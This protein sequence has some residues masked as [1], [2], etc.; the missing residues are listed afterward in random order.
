M[1]KTPAKAAQTGAPAAIAAHWPATEIEM[2]DAAELIPYARNAR[3]HPEEQIAQI[4]ASMQRFGFTIPMLV[5]EDGTII[6]GHG[7]LMA[8]QRLGLEQVPVMVARGWSDEDRRLYTLADNRLA[9]TSEWD[10]DMLRIELDELRIEAGQDALDMMAFSDIDL[11]SILP[12]AL[13]EAGG[14]D[15]DDAPPVPEVPTTQPGDVWL[16]GEHRLMCGDSTSADQ[17]AELCAGEVD[18]WLTD[19][20][21]NVAYEGKTKDALTI[22]NDSMSDGTFREFLRAAYL[23]ADAVMKPGAVFYVWHA[24]SEGYNFRGAARD[25]GWQVRQCVIWAKQTMVLGR[26]DYQWRHEPC[27]Y[28]WKDG[29]AHYWGSDRKQTTL[30]EFDKPSRSA[31][32][33]TMKPVELFAYQLLN[34]STERAVVLD[35]FGGSGTTLIACEMHNRFARL[36]ELDPKYCDVI[37]RRWEEFTG[38]EAVLEGDERTFKEIAADRAA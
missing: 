24:D 13:R 9:E 19:P 4:A 14:T 28:G 5:A 27:L 37:V 33:P 20:P 25:A 35:S 34:S 38:Q 10:V 36:M 22:Q 26:Q 3:T 17:I 1:P 23:A 16:L 8:A 31:H 18:L 11:A 2:R 30:L 7:R 21:Y 6:A 15:P 12:A 32:H 29:A